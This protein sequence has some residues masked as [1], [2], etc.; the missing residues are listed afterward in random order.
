MLLVV[1]TTFLYSFQVDSITR[2]ARYELNPSFIA[3]L[4]E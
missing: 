3:P 4:P 1:T 2:K